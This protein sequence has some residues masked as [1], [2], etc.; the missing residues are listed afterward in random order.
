[1][2]LTN[3]SHSSSRPS[4]E[5]LPPEGLVSSGRALRVKGK[6]RGKG[7]LDRESGSSVAE[8]TCLSASRTLGPSEE[9]LEDG[10]E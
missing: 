7:K 10:W 5:E 4:E 9:S 2:S 8:Y 1:M 6:E 3:T